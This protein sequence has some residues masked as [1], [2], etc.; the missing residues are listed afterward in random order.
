M[1]LRGGFAR[2]RMAFE[3]S[4]G[5]AAAC[6]TRLGRSP[7]F[8]SVFGSAQIGYGKQQ[9]IVRRI[10]RVK[11][12]MIVVVAYISQEDRLGLGLK[13]GIFEWCRRSRSPPRIKM[14]TRTA[15]QP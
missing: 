6:E 10:T 4:G 14:R 2:T 7:W 13:S 8:W 15:S 12:G 9:I 5:A 1:K 3:D 11:R